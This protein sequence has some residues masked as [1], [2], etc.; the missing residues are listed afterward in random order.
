[1]SDGQPPPDQQSQPV[2]E[3]SPPGPPGPPPGG[4]P[5]G[6]PPA[7]RAPWRQPIVLAAGAVLLLA[8]IVLGVGQLV[9][10]GVAAESVREELEHYSTVPGGV[11]DVSVSATP[12]IEL[13]WH[14][15]ERIDA[16]AQAL[17][18][19]PQQLAALARKL[20][21]VSEARLVV[22]SLALRFPSLGG[23][24]VTLQNATLAKHGGS[25]TIGGTVSPAGVGLTLPLG[26]RAQGLESVAGVPVVAVSGEA[27]GVGVTAHATITA[28]EG[29]LVVEPSG[30]PFAGLARVTLLS[31]PSIDVE[32]VSASP[33][34]DGVLLSVQAT[35]R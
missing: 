12:A 19:S 21:G 15:A 26:L 25:L 29:A 5:H 28:A 27:F 35:M 16:E 34:G 1:M 32:R 14:H 23:G 11:R 4:P 22:G 10:P 33:Q 31:D 2:P 8:A 9:L 6:G 20:S 18:I 7:A 24:Q 17:L 30:V 13:A 3:Q